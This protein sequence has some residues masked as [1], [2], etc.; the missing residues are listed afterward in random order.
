LSGC[1]CDE[2]LRRLIRVLAREIA[3]EVLDEHLD[4]YEHLLRQTDEVEAELGEG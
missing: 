4:D 2:E 1:N 3:Q